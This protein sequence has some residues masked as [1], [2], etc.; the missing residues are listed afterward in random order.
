MFVS[1]ILEN[2][3][4]GNVFTLENK[5]FH[6]SDAEIS[7]TD[8]SILKIMFNLENPL[9]IS[10]LLCFTEQ[11]GLIRSDLNSGQLLSQESLSYSLSQKRII[12]MLNFFAK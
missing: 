10:N 5:W 6:I 1:A 2:E 9:L 4:L 7:T 12:N 3:V 11:C 8:Q